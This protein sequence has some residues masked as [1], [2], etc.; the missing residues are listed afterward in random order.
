MISVSLFVIISLLLCII[1]AK[2]LE[3]I[4]VFGPM[5]LHNDAMDLFMKMRR[6]NPNINLDSDGEFL[7]KAKESA[8]KR[9]MA[10]PDEEV[11]SM[12]SSNSPYT[13]TRAGLHFIS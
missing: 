1:E 7:T 10:K 2:P 5:D 8:I 6:E 13:A 11:V 12:V 9:T 3:D 4:Q